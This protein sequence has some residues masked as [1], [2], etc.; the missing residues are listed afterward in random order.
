MLVMIFSTVRG[1]FIGKNL[2]YAFIISPLV[3]PVGL[4]IKIQTFSEKRRE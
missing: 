2:A 1:K 4:I 3:I